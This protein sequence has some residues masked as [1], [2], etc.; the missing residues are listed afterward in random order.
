MFADD[1]R[2][3]RSRK[4]LPDE[5]MK[6]G[7][8]AG[9]DQLNSHTCFNLLSRVRLDSTLHRHCRGERRKLDRRHAEARQKPVELIC[10]RV[11]ATNADCDRI[12]NA[13]G[14]ATR[15]T[16]NWNTSLIGIM[17]PILDGDLYTSA[18]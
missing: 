13:F 18:C 7:L 10:A 2:I 16:G 6:A 3:R 14:A 15:V 12:R 8:W 1:F 5:I 11:V 9:N 17:C 4:L